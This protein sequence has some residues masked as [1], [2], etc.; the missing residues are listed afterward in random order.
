MKFFLHIVLGLLLLSCQ[1]MPDAYRLLPGDAQGYAKLRVDALE[2]GAGDG[3]LGKW[4]RSAGLDRD[5][6]LLL[7]YGGGALTAV[8]P[9]SDAGRFTQAVK[10][11]S[12]FY[13]FPAP[14]V[15]WEGTLA[16]VATGPAGA[17]LADSPALHDFIASDEDL[18]LW[19]PAGGGV[20]EVRFETGFGRF[21]MR[22]E[23]EGSPDDLDGLLEKTGR[24][25]WRLDFHRP[26]VVSKL[27][28]AT[29]PVYTAADYAALDRADVA[30]SL[31]RREYAGRV[32]LDDEAAGSLAALL[33]PVEGKLMLLKLINNKKI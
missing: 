33:A 21:W 7:A 23:K 14:S 24:F 29:G 18:V 1:R 31:L 30:V 2:D 4:V 16:V 9:V 17:P 5:G 15:R 32:F 19:S 12:A 26:E 11:L 25:A 13:G 10:E 8:M 28:A 22:G 27:A 6:E 20:V 3:S